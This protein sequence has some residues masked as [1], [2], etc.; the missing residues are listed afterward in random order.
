[1]TEQNKKSSRAAALKGRSAQH[2]SGFVAFLREQG[3]VGLAVGFVL[4]AAAATLVK[5]LIEN[6][7]M[8]PIGI[9]LGSANGLKGLTFSLGVHDGK[10]VLLH[11][12]Q[13]LSDLVNF[14]ILALVVYLVVRVLQLERADKK[15]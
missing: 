3:V 11:Y 1:M 7:V 14:L 13:F 12:G 2:A 10:E 6:V 9:A 5:S 8:P 15:K 4:G